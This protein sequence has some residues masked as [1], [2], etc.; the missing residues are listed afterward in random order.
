MIQ[1]ADRHGLAAHSYADDAQLKFHEKTDQCQQHLSSLEACVN[2]I[3]KWMSSNQLKLNETQ[4]IW[5]G[6]RQQ[7]AKINCPAI[8]LAGNIINQSDDVTVLGVVF[9][10]EM[11]IR[12]HI[13]SF[14]G[15]C[16]YQLR[17]LSARRSNT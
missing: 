5:L 8:T 12:T 4:F 16:F 11:T 15:K 13:K 1:I 7:H 14:A 6:T 10:P 9:E 2:V 17:Q 3:S